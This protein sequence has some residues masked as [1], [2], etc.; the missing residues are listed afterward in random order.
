VIAID[1]QLAA[2]ITAGAS[3]AAMT[4]V[5]HTGKLGLVRDG[6]RL[7]RAGLTSVKEVARVVQEG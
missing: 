4:E 5:A 7:I 3:E 2:M 6:L 1:Q